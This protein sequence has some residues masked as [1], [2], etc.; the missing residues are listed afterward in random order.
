[1]REKENKP[2]SINSYPPQL[3]NTRKRGIKN[4]NPDTSHNFSKRT[5]SLIPC[6]L[7]QTTGQFK[8]IYLCNRCKVRLASILFINS[9]FH[10]VLFCRAYIK[11]VQ[12]VQCF[13][14]SC[15]TLLWFLV[16]VQSISE[17][18]VRTL[19]GCLYKRATFCFIPKAI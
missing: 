12:C 10:I 19:A 6:F 8:G 3:L 5:I 7:Y 15:P 14:L 17:C 16:L 1:M 11:Q 9:E 18:M 2:N 4:I 13:Q